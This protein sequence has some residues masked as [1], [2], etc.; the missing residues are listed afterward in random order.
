MSGF[1]VGMA[2]VAAVM[3]PNC[4][5]DRLDWSRADGHVRELL[6]RSS[7]PA[8]GLLLAAAAFAM[9]GGAVGAAVLAALSAVGLFANR[10][11][12]APQ[13][14][15]EVAPGVRKRPSRKSQRVVAVSLTLIFA[16]VGAI[17]GLL[18]VFAV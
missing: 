9:L 2:W 11:T 10:W 13:K 6:K 8:A 18:A 14:S 5:Y 17:G 15:R 7:G 12:L 1:A 16:A 4:S 3:S